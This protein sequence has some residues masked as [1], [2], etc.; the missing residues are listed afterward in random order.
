[1][2]SL[3]GV[4]GLAMV[5]AVYTALGSHGHAISLLALA[6]CLTPLVVAVA[7]PETSG[8]ALEEIAP[9]RG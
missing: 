5:G 2:A 7:F 9:E 3:G 4:C 6:F 1:M 8:R